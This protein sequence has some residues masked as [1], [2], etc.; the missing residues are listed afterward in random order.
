MQVITLCCDTP[1]LTL[2]APADFEASRPA[3]KKAR[4]TA[5][6]SK[7]VKK[8]RGNSGKLVYF[9]AMPLDVLCEV[10]CFCS[11][12]QT[13]SS[14]VD[15]GPLIAEQ[16]AGHLDPLTLL[17]MSRVNKTFRNLFMSKAARS[18]WMLARR[19]VYLP[20][21]QAEDMS[22]AA[23]ASLVF[24]KNCMVSCDRR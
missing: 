6:T 21:L 1:P 8:G 14:S 23:Y 19:S 20:D 10:S 7:V 9:Q 3:A 2:S 15:S 4:S 12:T 5:T 22:E 18:I 17:H 16:I 13:P 24:E 11:R